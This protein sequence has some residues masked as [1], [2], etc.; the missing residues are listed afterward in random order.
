VASLPFIA[1]GGLGFLSTAVLRWVFLGDNPALLEQNRINKDPVAF[2]ATLAR[3]TSSAFPMSHY[4]VN[5]AGLFPRIWDVGSM[6]K[7]MA[8][9]GGLAVFAGTLAACLMSLGYLP[10]RAE[11]R[12]GGRPGPGG[13]KAE[14]ALIGLLLGVL[15]AV[16]ISVSARHQAMI[17]PGI[18]YTPVYLQYFGVGLVLAVGAWSLLSMLSP[19]GT[20]R[21][22]A[23]M[24][25][26][27]LVAATAGL[28][29]R[30][31]AVVVDTLEKPHPYNPS[32][33]ATWGCWNQQRRNLESALRTGLL[34][35][36]P[37]HSVVLLANEYPG[38][39]DHPH[40]RYFYA[41]HSG[42][43]LETTPLA[44]CSKGDYCWFLSKAG[45][46][47]H[48]PAMR[49]STYLLRDVFQ[50]EGDGY[51]VLSSDAA[52]DGEG[53]PLPP[54]ASGGGELRVYVRHPELFEEGRGPDLV[55]TGQPPSPAGVAGGPRKVLT[56]RE[57]TRIRSGRDWALFPLPAEAGDLD[58][59]T[60]AVASGPVSASWDDGFYEPLVRR[61]EWRRWSD[62]RGVL[63][64]NN[65][66]ETPRKVKVS[67]LLGCKGK[68]PLL[69]AGGS[70]QTRVDAGSEPARFE[71]QLTLA[72][73]TNRVEI[74]SEGPPATPQAGDPRRLY[75][76]VSKFKIEDLERK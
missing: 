63:T 32:T 73:G 36:V 30:A 13:W 1:A 59:D 50:G 39:H 14:L 74:R 43:L 10:T 35:E 21:R 76:Y 54:G 22:R 75:F 44:S 55:I 23:R 40:S 72:P 70:I 45:R 29:Y 16:L 26:A 27:I 58:P 41:M 18:G 42:K 69:L 28:T 53:R 61:N 20:H 33:R 68:A 46:K 11:E 51:V 37:D 17:R 3:Q 64:L 7:F 8:T 31:N 24:A 2:L 12:A 60:L 49:P 5:P 25:M 52:R 4:L 34:D 15:P 67:M 56:G 9:A 71:R 57:L 65:A 48:G 38:W 6:I 62:R 19:G 47:P 66:T